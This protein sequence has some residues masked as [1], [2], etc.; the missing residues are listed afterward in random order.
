[1]SVACMKVNDSLPGNVRRHPVANLA[2]PD[3]LTGERD[4][5]DEE[6]LKPSRFLG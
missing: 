2:K 3:V 1:M 4:E 6:E 5:G